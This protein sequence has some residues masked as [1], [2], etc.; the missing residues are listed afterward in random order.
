MKIDRRW[1]LAPPLC[2]V[3]LVS[4]PAAAGATEARTLALVFGAIAVALATATIVVAARAR[5]ARRRAAAPPVQVRHAAALDDGGRLL[6]VHFAGRELLIA[7]G[8]DGG[9]RL[10]ADRG[11][12]SAPPS[13]VPT[14]AM[15]PRAAGAE[16]PVVIPR[17]EPAPSSARLAGYRAL[18]RTGR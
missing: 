2:A 15:S 7:H 16:P 1:L 12:V 6:V 17:P 4:G 5:P 9:V 14:S 3:L 13:A 10:L 8:R 18:T 11:P